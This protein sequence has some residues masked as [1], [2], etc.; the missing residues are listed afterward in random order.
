MHAIR[1]GTGKPVLPADALQAFLEG[2]RRPRPGGFWS[3]GEL[4]LFATS[5]RA[6]IGFVRS[7]Q[8][9]LP[10][11][12]GNPVGRTALLAQFSAGRSRIP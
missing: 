8:P 6:S 4:R 10:A 3:H 12:V 9:V 11:L 1:R 2:G 5:L 7:T